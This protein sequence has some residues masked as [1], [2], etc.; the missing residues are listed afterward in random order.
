MKNCILSSFCAVLYFSV[1][2]LIVH[3]CISGL[4]LSSD[5]DWQRRFFTLHILMMTTFLAL[6][7]FMTCNDLG[8]IF[9]SDFVLYPLIDPQHP[10]P[11]TLPLIP[12]HTFIFGLNYSLYLYRY[13][14][15]R[16]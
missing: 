9:T 2:F 16:D 4:I 10:H 13:N 8:I 11:I 12:V 15:P 14:L 3:S 6:H 5:F 1:F 7:I